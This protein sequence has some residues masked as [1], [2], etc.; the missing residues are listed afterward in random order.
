MVSDEKDV[1]K[2]IEP[3][4][5]KVTQF[6]STYDLSYDSDEQ[7]V[8]FHDII[9]E[10]YYTMNFFIFQAFIQA[11]YHY[12]KEIQDRI[13]NALLNYRSLRIT[14]SKKVAAVKDRVLP[15]FQIIALQALYELPEVEMGI[16]DNKE[17]LADYCLQHYG[18]TINI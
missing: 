2:V 14:P 1:P 15:D 6:N 8:L 4:Q 18:V 13:I 16:D 10:S 3:S 9:Y 7:T 17:E 12:S 11:S 5:I